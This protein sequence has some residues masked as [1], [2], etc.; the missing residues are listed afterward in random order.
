[1]QLGQQDKAEAMYRA[2]LEYPEKL[3]QPPYNAWVEDWAVRRKDEYAETCV[4]LGNLYFTKGDLA[5][6]EKYY[7]QALKLSPNAVNALK[8]LAILYGQQGKRDA[9]IAQWQKLQSIAPRDPDVQRVF[10]MQPV[11]Q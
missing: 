5:G 6:A 3:K 8:N 4:N 1:M 7:Q 10:Q 9:A 2:H 11:R